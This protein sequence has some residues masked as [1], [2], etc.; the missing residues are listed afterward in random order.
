MDVNAWLAFLAACWIISLSPGSGAVASMS[1]GVRF[2]FRH[3]Y[4]NVVGL[5]LA[6]ALQIAIVAAGVGAILA[7]SV[8]AFEFIKWLGVVYLLYLGWQQWCAIPTQLEENANTNHE[9]S[10]ALSLIGNGFLINIS[11]PKAIVFILAVLPQFL[12]PAEPQIPQYVIMAVTM[13][14]VDM[15]VMA[16]YTGLAAQV[17]RY[18]K[19]PRQQKLLNRSFA[20]MF[21]GAASMLSVVHR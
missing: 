15:I 18:L 19:S 9:Q 20:V 2:G 12:D 5:Q 10:S 16:G 8:L 11:N 4:W 1:S 17:L 14:A 6:L 7:T 3:G 13:I 21:A